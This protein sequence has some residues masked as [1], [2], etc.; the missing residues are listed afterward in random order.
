[1]ELTALKRQ[2]NGES[3]CFARDPVEFGKDGKS[4]Q[5]ASSNPRKPAQTSGG[6]EQIGF[7][8]TDSPSDM[9]GRRE[10]FARRRVEICWLVVAKQ[11]SFH[12]LNNT[13]TQFT[14]VAKED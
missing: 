3:V 5:T 9:A 6:C 1:M 10:Q 14:A 4:T 12:F 13:R 8:Q 7:V 11:D 2:P